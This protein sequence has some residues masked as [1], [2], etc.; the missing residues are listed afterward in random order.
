MG[1]LVDNKFTWVIQN[2][3][4]SQSRVVSSDQFVMGGCRWYDYKLSSSNVFPSI[5]ILF[6][7]VLVMIRVFIYLCRRLRA[8]PQ[9]YNKSDHLSL[10][11]EVA[12]YKLLPPGWKRHA[13]YLLTIVNQNSDKSSKRN[14]YYVFPPLQHKY[15]V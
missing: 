10:F 15:L 11:L 4:Y 6:S 8:Y 5:L 9:G 13:R 2:F 1:N 14:G 3:S 12:D 7:F